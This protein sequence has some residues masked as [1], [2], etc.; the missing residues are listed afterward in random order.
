MNVVQRLRYAKHACSVIYI[1]P[2]H[3]LRKAVSFRAL[4]RALTF[5]DSS[6]MMMVLAGRPSAE[7]ADGTE[8][9]LHAVVVCSFPPWPICPVVPVGA[10]EGMKSMENSSELTVSL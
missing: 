6:S 10:R 3:A 9:I 2:P 8:T 7:P 1:Y 4:M 5:P